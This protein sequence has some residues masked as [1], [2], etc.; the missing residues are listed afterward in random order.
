MSTTLAWA[1]V[2]LAIGVEVAGTSLLPA[3]GGFSRLVP[4]VTVL[5]LYGIS[6]ALLAKA[7]SALQVSVVYAVWSAVGTA[8]IATIGVLWLGEPLSAG[9]V[10][11]LSLIVVGVVVL[12]LAGTTR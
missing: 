2:A 3:T 5:V 6:F 10:L 7:V 8:A 9:K 1:L 4:T 12:N 11:G